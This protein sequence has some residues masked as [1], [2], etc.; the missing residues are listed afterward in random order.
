LRWKR[1]VHEKRQ[2]NSTV[3]T[4]SDELSAMSYELFL[5]RSKNDTSRAN[6][7]TVRFHGSH[8]GLAGQTLRICIFAHEVNLII[9]WASL[10][11]SSVKRGRGWF[12]AFLSATKL[13]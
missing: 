2:T 11:S 4:V 8:A 9:L 7:I 13:V 5:I 3:F 6:L 12:V 10:S 1:S